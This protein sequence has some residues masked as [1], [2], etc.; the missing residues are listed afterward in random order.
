MRGARALGGDARE[1]DQRAAALLRAAGAGSA[2]SS[3]P[4]PT[5]L[6]RIT[7]SASSGSAS[8]PAWA[9]STPTA[10]TT[11]SNRPA[12]SNARRSR[13]RGRRGRRRRRR[14]RSTGP[15]ARASE[16]SR[17]PLEPVAVAAEQADGRTGPSAASRADDREPDLGGAADQ[18]HATVGRCGHRAHRAVHQ[19]GAQRRGPSATRRS[20][21]MRSR[22]ARHSSSRGYIA[23]QR[24]GTQ[25]RVLGQIDAAAG[26][27]RRARR[28]RRAAASRPG[29]RRGRSSASVQ[30]GERERQRRAL[31]GAE[32]LEHREVAR[33]PRARAAARSPRSSTSAPARA[34]RRAGTGRRPSRAVQPRPGVEPVER[35]HV[36]A[37]RLDAA[38]AR[39]RGARRKRSSLKAPDRSSGAAAPP[40]QPRGHRA[41]APRRSARAARPRRGSAPACAA[42]VTIPRTGP[43]A[44]Q[45]EPRDAVRRRRARSSSAERVVER[46]STRSVSTDSSG[47][48]PAR[49][50]SAPTRSRRSAPCRRASPRTARRSSPASS[51]STS[52]RGGQQPERVDVAAERPGGAV[53]LA[54]DIAGDRAADGDVLG[55]GDDG[56][57]PARRRRARP[58]ARRA[59]TP[60]CG[61]DGPASRVELE[62]VE[63]RGVEHDA[64]VAAGPRRR[65]CAPS[66]AR[67]RRAPAA[68]R[69]ASSERGSIARRGR[70]GA[71]RAGAAAPPPQPRRPRTARR[72]G[73][74]RPERRAQLSR[75]HGRSART[76]RATRRRRAQRAVAQQQLLGRLARAGCGPACRSAAGR[77]A[78]GID[79]QRPPRDAV[80]VGQLERPHAVGEQ[81]AAAPLSASTSRR[82]RGV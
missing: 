12:S 77:R 64:A 31:G 34:G 25:P 55:A 18:Q 26:L 36:R 59:S 39:A 37:E 1:H 2:S 23:A 8:S 15:H 14:R 79:G 52:P 57:H 43:R 81:R 82:P 19:P 7:S 46:S 51:S 33:D 42:R 32:V 75:R 30:P 24:L 9:P 61:R 45:V 11:T 66:R 47:L 72:R 65:S 70:S 16:R 60:A 5:K 54:V 78:N 10:S 74:R 3:E 63:P 13:A 58:A 41:R 50:G 35:E 29:A 4:A 22:T 20:G 71:S 21:S 73:R 40:G 76:A 69:A 28:S 68:G 80:D 56:H 67:S 6:T 62:P 17:A 27:A 38:R 53:V 48:A 49:A 44:E